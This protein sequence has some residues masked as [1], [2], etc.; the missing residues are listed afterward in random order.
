MSSPS[1]LPLAILQAHW[2]SFS[3]INGLYTDSPAWITPLGLYFVVLCCPSS[4]TL[5]SPPQ[6]NFYDAPIYIP[7]YP[8][9]S[10]ILYYFPCGLIA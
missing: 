7:N 9:L 1:C 5:N 10:H 8:I 2:A 3:S 6:L 4:L